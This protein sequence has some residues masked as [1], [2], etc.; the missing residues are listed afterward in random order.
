MSYGTY[1]GELSICKTK[2]VL[3]LQTLLTC[4]VNTIMDTFG[5]LIYQIPVIGDYL[6]LWII[7]RKYSCPVYVFFYVSV[8]L[9][10]S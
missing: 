5:T 1:A 10:T 9:H 2:T 6:W 3:E 4:I 7:D 8:C